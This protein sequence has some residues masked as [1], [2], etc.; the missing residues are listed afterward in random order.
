MKLAG[1]VIL[2]QT[3]AD[4]QIFYTSELNSYLYRQKHLYFLLE[5]Q[6]IV[7]HNRKR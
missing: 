1:K 5:D 6:E 7:H 4:K 3:L 2:L